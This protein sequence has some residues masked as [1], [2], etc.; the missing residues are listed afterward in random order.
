VAAVHPLR[1]TYVRSLGRV[2]NVLVLTFR[3]WVF[4]FRQQRTPGNKLISY[5]EG[6]KKISSFSSVSANKVGNLIL[7]YLL[8]HIYRLNPFG[9]SGRIYIHRVHLFLPLTTCSST[10]ASAGQYGKTLSISQAVNGSFV[11]KKACPTESG[12]I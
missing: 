3:S 2:N 9:G 10:L 1:N 7:T 8:D 4:W 6:I 5:E 12:K 11:S